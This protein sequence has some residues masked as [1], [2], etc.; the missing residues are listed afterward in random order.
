M[1]KNYNADILFDKFLNDEISLKEAKQLIRLIMDYPKIYEIY[2]QHAF[3]P[4]ILDSRK[5]RK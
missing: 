3:T 4:K 5:K 2:K 1:E